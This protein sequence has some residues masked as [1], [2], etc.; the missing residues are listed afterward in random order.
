[1]SD[2]PPS[3]EEL[4]YD[5][6]F[7]SSLAALGGDLTP[8]RIAIAHGESYIA[9]TREGATKAILVGHRPA[10]WREA[11]ERPQVGDWVAGSRPDPAGP[12]CIARLLERRTCLMRR[13]AGERLAAQ[14]IAS[15]V[16]TVGVVSALSD[17]ADEAKEKRS[18]N[19]RRLQRYL[20]AVEQSG[21][22]AALIFNK[23]DLCPD[24]ER[25]AA[26]FREL[27]A[28]VPLLLTS[29][30]AGSGVDA[31]AELAA[32][33]KTLVLVGMSGVGKST[34]VNSL[35]GRDAQQV[36]GVRESDGRGRHT[37][38]NRE[39]FR[40]PNGGLLIDTPGMR[41]LGLWEADG[42]EVFDDVVALA[43]GCRFSD[44]RHESEPGC[45]ILAAVQTGALTQER[46]AS[47]C[48]HIRKLAEPRAHQRG[49]PRSMVQ[50]VP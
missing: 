24:A 35:L 31:V 41:E 22:K 42:T 6:H 15:N 17:G 19:E 4:G 29:G 2:A 34:L 45:A 50:G 8:A 46:W 44:C 47:Y 21:A 16:D 14:V 30:S 43:R 40:L 32:P 36:Y 33:G 23:S 26:G 37:T 9:W 5:P 1:M 3:L 49:A 10:L 12:L 48:E 39:L 25:V 18:V 13:A 20:T 28:G 11:A 27:F 7:E 38:T